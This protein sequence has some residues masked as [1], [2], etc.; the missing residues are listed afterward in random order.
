MR[1]IRIKKNS[2]RKIRIKR[3]R[4]PRRVTASRE[5]LRAPGTRKSLAKAARN[6]RSKPRKGRK[7]VVR[8]RQRSITRRFAVKRR[9][10]SK[11]EIYV[12][13]ADGYQLVADASPRQ[14]KRSSQHLIAIN[15]F[16]RKDDTEP[17]EQFQG[18]RIAGIQLLTDPKRIREFADAD[19]VK[20]DGLY[21]DQR[22]HGRRH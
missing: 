9:R 16:L 14:A 1:R 4:A 10:R 7:I 20:L 8:K 3:S 11:R 17:L 6:G 2:K 21:R 15:R 12:F 5:R 13:T 19:E 22:G 18:R